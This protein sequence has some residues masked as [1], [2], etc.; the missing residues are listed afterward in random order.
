MSEP[1]HSDKPEHAT[2][3]CPARHKKKSTAWVIVLF[4]V[5]VLLI[6][7]GL[8][9]PFVQQ[10]SDGNSARS[11]SINNMKQLGLAM[12]DYHDAYGTL[13]QAA[14][15]DKQGKPLLSWR[16]AILPFI[17]QGELY[18]RF[19]LDEQ[20]DSPNNIKLLEEMPR[21]YVDPRGA[22]AESNE[23]KTYYRV[24]QGERTA[25]GKPLIVMRTNTIL[26]V[27]AA[28]AVPWT[29]P[30]ELD[31]SPTAASETGREMEQWLRIYGRTGRWVC[32]DG[33]E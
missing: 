3:D 20:W 33:Q 22:D 14:I 27:E 32:A 15:T 17:E 5:V 2:D 13:P 28:E 7:V 25:P 16:V 23:F 9:W 10:P 8:I 18:D 11:R 31:Y 12:H 21:I 6:C 30:E 24:F 1:L 26:I 19:R 29:K 4:W